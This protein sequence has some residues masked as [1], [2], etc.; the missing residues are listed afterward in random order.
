MLD[1]SV[2]LGNGICCSLRRPSIESIWRRERMSDKV[3][4]FV[5][6]FALGLIYA[7]ACISRA[8]ITIVTGGEKKEEKEDHHD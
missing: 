8:N 1:I 7:C 3:S 2:G 5:C 6:G 4:G